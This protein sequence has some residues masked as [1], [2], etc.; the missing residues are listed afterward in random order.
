[1]S[2]LMPLGE[3]MDSNP[4]VV[5]DSMAFFFWKWQAGRQGVQ[6]PTAG[7]KASIWCPPPAPSP[8]TYLEA[9]VL[10]EGGHGVGEA[11]DDDA[12]EPALQ[13]GRHP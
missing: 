11:L 3:Y 2:P 1:M 13:D 10:V 7:G 6:D 9:P 12:V 8:A 5:N 4:L